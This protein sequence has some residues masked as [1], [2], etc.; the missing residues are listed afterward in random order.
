MQTNTDI[1]AT[2][3]TITNN[4]V[5]DIGVGIY[6]SKP[7]NVEIA[8]NVI[9]DIWSINAVINGGGSAIRAGGTSNGDTWDCN[10]TFH[11]SS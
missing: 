5:H 2:N 11:V 3:L 4:T 9:Y 6:I 7:I 8:H 1:S 10:Y